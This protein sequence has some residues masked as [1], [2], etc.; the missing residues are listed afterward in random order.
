MQSITA[1][2][3]INN[4][5]A[6]A[7]L[8]LLNSAHS[9]ADLTDQIA[10]AANVANRMVAMIRITNRLVGIDRFLSIST[11]EVTCMK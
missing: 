3:E 1:A 11:K 7:G 10:D 5:V 2:T 8:T 9:P 4:G 6:A